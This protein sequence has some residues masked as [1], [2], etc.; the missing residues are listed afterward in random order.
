MLTNDPANTVNIEG[1]EKELNKIRP[2]VENN[3]LTIYANRKYLFSKLTIY[4]SALTLQTI[5]LNG[6]GNISP[7]DFIKCDHLHISLNGNI[8]VKFK[9]MGEVS[10][11]KPDD[12]EL[13]KK[14]R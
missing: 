11:D 1:K 14:Q 7:I 3:I 5:E 12:I 10:F 8:N 13:L 9:T 4:L 2:V 6:D